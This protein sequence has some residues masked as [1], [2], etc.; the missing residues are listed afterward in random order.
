MLSNRIQKLK[1]SATLA[2]NAKA[3]ELKK[4]GVDIVKFGTGEPD[5]DTP[6]NIK[7]AA[8]AAMD[9]GFTK[10]TAASGIPELKE[11]VQDKLERDNNIKCDTSNILISNGG[12]QALFNC[13]MAILNPCDEVIIP[14]PYWVSY[15]DMVAVCG[16]LSVFVDTKPNNFKLTAEMVASAIT[17]KTK[18]LILNSPS[19]PTGAVIEQEEIEKIAALA[20][21]HNFYVI[22]DEVYEYFL[23]DGK[24]MFSIGSM[25]AMKDLV[26]T[27]NAV[28]KSYSMTGWRIGYIAGPTDVIKPMSNLQAH[29]TSNPCS[30]AQKAALEALTGPQDSIGMMASEF[31]KR[32]DYVYEAMSKIPGFK[33]HKPE[34]AFYAFIDVSEH[35]TD[36]IKDSFAFTEFLMEKARVAVVP[37]GAFGQEGNDY[38]RFSYT[39]SVEDIEEGIRRIKTVL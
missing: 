28:S 8:K 10:Y 19:N 14:S 21:E 3:I 30:I 20:L 34:G 26:F 31:A 9:A 33:L 38:I 27:V 16:G 18:A 25:P 7:N 13:F 1:P 12:K 11:A 32:R 17:P 37:G 2:I 29:A 6:E 22:S 39:S 23:Y 35:F 36:N 4:Q 5:C 15:S 24:K